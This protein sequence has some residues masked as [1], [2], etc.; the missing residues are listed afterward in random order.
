MN[1][2]ARKDYAY[3]MK[4]KKRKERKNKNTKQNKKDF[5]LVVQATEWSIRKR[6]Y[7]VRITL[8]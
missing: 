5:S 6:G 2:R 7:N 8:V 3:G 1:V 4:V